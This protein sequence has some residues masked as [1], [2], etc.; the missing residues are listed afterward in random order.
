MRCDEG[1]RCKVCGSDVE[2]IL[3]SALY[4][5]YVLGEIP[6]EQLHLHPE[7]HIRCNRELAQYII[8]DAFLPVECEGFFDKRQ[9]DP[10]FVAAE[11]ARVTAAWRQLQAIPTA[12]VHLI[13]YP[14]F[15]RNVG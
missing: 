7:S 8:D 1:Y 13:D 2:S 10:E 9:L 6:L 3:D 4:L 11:E 5:R 12:G 15:R 14:S